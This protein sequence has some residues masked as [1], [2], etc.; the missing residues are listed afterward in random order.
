MDDDIPSVDIRVR[1]RL[2]EWKRLPELQEALNDFFHETGVKILENDSHLWLKAIMLVQ[3]P[4]AFN[5]RDEVEGLRL[6][7]DEKAML[8]L[9]REPTKAERSDNRRRPSL[10]WNDYARWR[11]LPWQH[12]KIMINCAL[13][14]IT[15]GCK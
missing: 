5:L 10:E 2:L 8:D 11:H 6:T 3:N 4:T 15:Q 7:P 13:A 14:A 1:V 9:D 12:W